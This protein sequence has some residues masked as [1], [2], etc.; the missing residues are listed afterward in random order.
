LVGR[1]RFWTPLRVVLLIAV[2]V[3]AVGWLGKAACLQQYPSAN[4]GPALDWRNNRQY[5]AMCYSDTVPLYRIEGLDTGAL[6][7]RDPWPGTT[8]RF[9]EYPVLTGLAQWA[10]ARLADGWLWLG[11]RVPLWPVGLAEVVYFDLAAVWLS[12]A[13][14][15]V[16]WAVHGL[17]PERP[18]DAALIALS[19]LALVHVLTAS[20]AAATACAAAGLL[21]LARGR[22]LLA[23]ALIGLGGG[24]G[25]WP[26]VLLLPVA[27]VAARRARALVALRVTTAAAVV[28]AAANLPVAV[29]YPRGW[30]EFFRLQLR[31]GADVDSLWFAVSSLTGRPGLDGALPDGATPVA[32]TTVSVALFVACCAGIG[33]L[34][35]RAPRP[36][37]L[38]SLAF[39]LVAALLLTGKAW[40]PQWSL[41]LVPLAVLALPRWRPLL[42]WMAVDALLWVPRMSYFVGPGG[43]GLTPEWFLGAVLVRDAVVLGLCALVVRSVLRPGTDPVRLLGDDD[44]EWPARAC[45]PSHHRPPVGP[46]APCV[47]GW[48]RARSAARP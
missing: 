37:R 21:A 19:P 9:S 8:D 35:W 31:R 18:W 23:G 43:R 29:L 13:W 14:L 48:H 3:L 22:P 41:W 7:Y 25:I 45:T 10:T 36:P 47:D 20:D 26:L 15:V 17:R 24:F 46:P 12:F 30:S 33:V 42:A 4:G 6:P 38:A 32:L 1:S 2:A 11:E 34:A 28:W 5:V 40:S 44:P 39:L 16:V 27:L